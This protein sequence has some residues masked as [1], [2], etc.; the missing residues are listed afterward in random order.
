MKFLEHIRSYICFCLYLRFKQVEYFLNTMSVVI[1]EKDMVSNQYRLIR[2]VLL[3]MDYVLTLNAIIFFILCVFIRTSSVLVLFVCLVCYW[4]FVFFSLMSL[5][6]EYYLLALYYSRVVFLFCV[7][8]WIFLMT[9][10]PV[11]CIVCYEFK[12]ISTSD[13]VLCVCNF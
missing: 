2:H 9:G 12:W 7:F 13:L 5:L 11:Y 1:N 4:F 6:T 10:Y 3:S 8:S